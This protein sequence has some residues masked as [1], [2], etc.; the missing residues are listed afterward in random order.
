MRGARFETRWGKM[1]LG[2][3]SLQL[4]TP[5]GSYAVDLHDVLIKEKTEIDAAINEERQRP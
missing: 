2:S 3:A 5:V 4:R 1:P